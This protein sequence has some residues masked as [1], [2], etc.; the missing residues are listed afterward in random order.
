[1]RDKIKPKKIL[2]FHVRYTKLM[3]IIEFHI[4]INKIL[5][6]LEF[7]AIIMETINRR[8]ASENHENHESLKIARDNQENL[9]KSLNSMSES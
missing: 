8:I 1:M 2:R 6:I 5:K 7:L 4:R 9:E 3:I